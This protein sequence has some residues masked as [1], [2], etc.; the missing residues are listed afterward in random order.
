MSSTFLEKIVQCASWT[1]RTS[2]K[3]PPK[4][5]KFVFRNPPQFPSRQRRRHLKTMVLPES[6]IKCFRSHQN[7]RQ[8]FS[9][10]SGLKRAY[11]NLCLRDGLV[12]TVGC[13]FKFLL[14][15]VEVEPHRSFQ[16]LTNQ[17]KLNLCNNFLYFFLF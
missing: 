15:S 14:Y 17:K 2:W 12:W 11:E 1:A 8:A 6:S 4:F 9:Y 5:F 16:S 7:A 3:I 10:P 13:V